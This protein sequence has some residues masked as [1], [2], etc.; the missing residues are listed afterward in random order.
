MLKFLLLSLL[1][2]S[3]Y[4]AD[5]WDT[6]DK[7]LG[8]T[9]LTFELADLGQT[10]SIS[11]SCHDNDTPL[12]YSELNPILGTCPKV[13]SVVQYFAASILVSGLIAD[14]L[15]SNYRK[16]FLTGAILFEFDMVEHNYRG[17]ISIKF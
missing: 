2:F 9:A 8:A 7:V 4:A 3:A 12:V 6:T 1:S 11:H 14:A 16:A 13:S 10:I 15:P 17:G 5:D